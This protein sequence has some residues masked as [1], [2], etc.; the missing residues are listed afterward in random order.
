MNSDVQLDNFN[1]TDA[2]RASYSFNTKIAALV[3]LHIYS[4]SEQMP[5]NTSRLIW[6]CSLCLC[7]MHP[8]PSWLST[9]CTSAFQRPLLRILSI[10]LT[11]LNC[12]RHQPNSE[13][14]SPMKWE[15][16]GKQEKLQLHTIIGNSDSRD[17]RKKQKQKKKTH[18][19]AYSRSPIRPSA[20]VTLL[21]PC[22]CR[23]VKFV[24]TR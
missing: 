18:F 3:L 13:G 14:V 12:G 9:S 8:P 17:S 20:S 6:S 21:S 16:S 10:Q 4:Q 2:E 11:P 15:C 1:N 22:V 19:P 24:H 5:V 7:S 23:P